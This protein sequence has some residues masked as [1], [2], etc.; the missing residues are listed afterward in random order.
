M[1]IRPRLYYGSDTELKRKWEILLEKA[2]V[3]GPGSLLFEY[4]G[5]EIIF[6]GPCRTAEDLMKYHKVDPRKYLARPIESTYWETT[7]KSPDGPITK[8]N[9]RLKIKVIPRPMEVEQFKEFAE[10][11]PKYEVKEVEG[12]TAHVI[13][14]DLHMGAVHKEYNLK[15]VIELLSETAAIVN[16]KNYKRVIVHCAGDVLESYTGKNHAD[17]WKSIEMWGVDLIKES[18]KILAHFLDQINNLVGF[19]L[20]G[21]NHDRM[22]DKTENDS[23]AG[24]ADLIAYILELRGYPVKFDPFYLVTDDDGF[25]LIVEHGNWPLSKQNPYEK[26]FRLGAQDKF[27]IIVQGHDHSRKIG[28]SPDGSNYRQITVPSF[29]PSTDY[30][31]Q[32]GAEGTSGFMIIEGGRKPVVIDYTL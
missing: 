12:Q 25:R 4:D 7:M 17:T 27:N 20:V 18:S 24:A 3:D 19:T 26:I 14:S 1:E 23:K 21:G 10:G 32:L 9:H 6:D 11:L 5:G 2:R 8:Q 15:K 29:I 28:R 31:M 16:S 13:I 22:S 30:G